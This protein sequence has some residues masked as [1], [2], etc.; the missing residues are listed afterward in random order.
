MV[1]SEN[2]R[3]E[4]PGLSLACIEC[5]PPWAVHS[6]GLYGYGFL[7]GPNQPQVADGCQWGGSSSIGSSNSPVN[8]AVISQL[9]FT[10]IYDTLHNAVYIA[11]K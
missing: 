2:L 11:T 1:F 8:S 7:F 10:Y 6:V 4:V 3:R 5:L 9:P